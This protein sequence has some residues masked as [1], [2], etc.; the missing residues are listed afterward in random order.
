MSLAAKDRLKTK[1]D[2]TFYEHLT[3]KQRM[4]SGFPY[5]EFDEE[6][7]IERAKARRI[8]RE[9]NTLSGDDQQRRHELIGDLFDPACRE[10]KIFIEPTFNVHYGG[11]ISVGDNVHVDFDCFFMDCASITIGANCT[12]GPGVHI[13][14]AL[15]PTN[16]KYRKHTDDFFEL[17]FPVRIGNN[18]HIGGRVTFCPGVMVGDNVII[19]T[20]SVVVK[21][22]PSNS[23][24]V[25]N[26]AKVV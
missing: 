26:P 14:T 7:A 13:Y 15:H 2:S 20:G 10:N 24:A 9:F 11:N 6:L 3:E 16:P 4:L 12:I 19:E 5:D 23:I 18:C 17:A 22:I 21:D 1:P 25:G 8:L